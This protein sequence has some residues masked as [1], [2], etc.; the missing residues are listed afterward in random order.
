[1]ALI[2]SG[3]SATDLLTVDSASKAARTTLY[4]NTGNVIVYS[5]NAQPTTALSGVISMAINDSQVVGTRADRIGGVAS[6]S[7]TPLF[8][9]SFEG[10]TI[11]TSRW[12]IIQSTM[13]SSQSSATGATLNSG[14]ITTASTGSLIFSARRFLKMQRNPLQARFRLRSVRVNNSV[15]EWGFGDVFTSNSLNTVGAYWQVTASGVTQ[16]VITF[17]GVDTTGADIS[18][19]IDVTRFYTFDVI[20]DDDEVVFFCQDTASGRVLSRQVLRLPLTGVRTFS[21]SQL[22]I[23]ARVYNTSTA[24]ASAPTLI[25]SDSLV[26]SLESVQN[27]AWSDTLAQMDRSGVA[28]PLTGAQLSQYTNN[29]EPANATLSNTTAG[30]STLGGKF[31]FAAVAGSTTDYALFGFQVPAPLNFTITSVDIESWNTGAVVATT[32]TLLT[33]AIGVSSPF[34]TLTGGA[35]L[36]KVGLGAQDFPVGAAIG[37]RAQRVSKTFRVGLHT[38]NARFVHIILRIPIG[39]ATASQVIAGMVNIE[40]FFD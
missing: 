34:V 30:Y 31:Q 15:Q 19:L 9:D 17:N 10:T 35:P 2:S 38:A 37:S 28:N 6:S 16:P 21:T 20:L 36:S 5:D 4:D 14:N 40:G 13:I 12:S 18:S 7:N 32:P 1:M 23:F 22:A 3:V 26:T 33:W 27:K 29:A 24:P 25:L 8:V 11:N 39:T